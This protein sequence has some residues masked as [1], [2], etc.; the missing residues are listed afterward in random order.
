MGYVNVTV[1]DEKLLAVDKYRGVLLSVANV[2]GDA[3]SKYTPKECYGPE[4][5]TE[6]GDTHP[7]L[8]NISHMSKKT[9]QSRIAKIREELIKE[10]LTVVTY[11]M[12]ATTPNYD[13]Y[14]EKLSS[15]NSSEVEYVAIATVGPKDIIDKHTKKLTLA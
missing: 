3:C 14:I 1:Y 9:K 10:G 11:T 6:D 13:E 8:T 15:K 7:S 5:T 2:L 12:D 4:V